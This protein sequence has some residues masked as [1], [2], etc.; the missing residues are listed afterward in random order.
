MQEH[1][2]PRAKRKYP[3]TDLWSPGEHAAR[4]QGQPAPRTSVQLILQKPRQ[5]GSS[6][7][8]RALKQ[9]GDDGLL[10]PLSCT[11]MSQASAEDLGGFDA[12]C[13]QCGF[14]D[15]QFLAPKHMSSTNKWHW[16]DSPAGCEGL[17]TSAQRSSL[18]RA[19]QIQGSINIP[20][21][22]FGRPL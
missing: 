9:L 4:L 1:L 5:A 17:I 7:T 21:I 11:C 10:A 19:S 20:G 12:R 8:K 22:V 16:A 3:L 6:Q 2:S 13:A 18:L 14:R 15:Y